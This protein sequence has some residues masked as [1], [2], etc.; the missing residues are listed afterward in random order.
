MP[1]VGDEA[2][3]KPAGCC[4]TS[5]SPRVRPSRSVAFEQREC[6]DEG[7]DGSWLHGRV[8]AGLTGANA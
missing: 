4:M 6:G 8:K 1:E 3:P 7:G 2:E 5:I